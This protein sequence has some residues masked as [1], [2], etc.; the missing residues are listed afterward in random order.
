[1]VNPDGMTVRRFPSPVL[2]EEEASALP[3]QWHFRFRANY[4][5]R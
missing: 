1:M 5:L 2:A 4:C 3:V